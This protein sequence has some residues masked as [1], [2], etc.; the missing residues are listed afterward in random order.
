MVIRKVLVFILC[1]VPLCLLIYQIAAGQLGPDVGKALVLATGIWALRFLLLALAVTP[2]R[3]VTRIHELA[4][5]RRMIGLYAWFYASLHFLVVLT[6]LLGWS[7]TIFIEEFSERPYMTLGITA[8]VLMVPLGLTSNR[9]A[10]RRMG[11]RWKSLHKA[12]YLIGVLACAHFIWL[13]RSDYAEALTYS[14]ILTVLLLVRVGAKYKRALP[15]IGR[16]SHDSA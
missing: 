2:L 16:G 14:L 11:R 9:W 8:W 4:Q 13:I 15:R 3:Q 6:Y 1:L 7:W 5:L 12:V 10:Q